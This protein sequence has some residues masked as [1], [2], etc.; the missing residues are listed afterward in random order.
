[1]L[2]ETIKPDKADYEE[3]P[4]HAA[5]F[6]VPHKATMSICVPRLNCRITGAYDKVGEKHSSAS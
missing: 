3:P 6:L 2:H 5:L 1:M 4:R